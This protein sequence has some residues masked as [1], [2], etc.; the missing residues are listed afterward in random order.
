MFPPARSAASCKTQVTLSLKIKKTGDSVHYKHDGN[1]FDQPHTLKLTESETYNLQLT[2]SGDGEPSIVRAELGGRMIHLSPLDSTTSMAVG[3]WVA[4]CLRPT[5]KSTRDLLLLTV[6]VRTNDGVER[7]AVF[8]LQIKTYPKGPVPSSAAGLPLARLHFE[9]QWD[10]ATPAS[11][12]AKANP[13]RFSRRHSASLLP[14]TDMLSQDV[15][16]AA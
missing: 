10:A 7:S 5:P 13:V 11:P 16:S 4:D 3:S 1:R 14:N 2:A 9:M 8:P 6:H 15:A 12:V